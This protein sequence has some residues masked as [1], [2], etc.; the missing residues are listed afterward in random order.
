MKAEQC[1]HAMRLSDK[2]VRCL[3]ISE[4]I[5]W[6]HAVHP[7]A[8]E[9]C[10]GAES[11]YAQHVIAALLRLRVTHYW[12]WDDVPER[13]HQ[14]RDDMDGTVRLLMQRSGRQTAEDALVEAVRRGMSQERATHIAERVL[15]AEVKPG[16]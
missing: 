8:C 10:E 9:R 11:P 12:Q 2:A 15:G 16:G 5:G 1:P 13:V 4:V 3:A 14:L 6:N 7:T